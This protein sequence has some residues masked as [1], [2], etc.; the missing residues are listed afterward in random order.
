ML[1][2]SGSRDVG[3][4]DVGAVGVSYLTGFRC[5]RKIRIGIGTRR[6][7]GRD[8]QPGQ[9]AGEVRPGDTLV[10]P[11]TDDDYAWHDFLSTPITLLKSTPKFG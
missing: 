5:R 2:A 7:V 4:V 1:A 3:K 11:K 6:S 8:D 10:G 9:I